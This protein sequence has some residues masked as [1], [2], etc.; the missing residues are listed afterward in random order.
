MQPPLG[1]ARTGA[2]GGFSLILA[3]TGC[4]CK[5]N[6]E[7]QKCFCLFL[8]AAIA[9]GKKIQVTRFAGGCRFR[10]SVCEPLM[11]LIL[12]LTIICFF[13]GLIGWGRYAEHSVRKRVERAVRRRR[14]PK[15]N[16]PLLR[17]RVKAARIRGPRRVVSDPR[18]VFPE[19]WQVQCR[20]CGGILHCDSSRG[21][22]QFR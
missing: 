7:A 3:Q 5:F 6:I 17:A 14:C 16:Q 10:Q 15:C 12:A 19:A 20:R 22:I 4:D 18:Q 21:S 1:R 8:P 2:P 9:A 11:N 13:L